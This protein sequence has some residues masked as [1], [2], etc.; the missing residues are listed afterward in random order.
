MVLA[1]VPPTAYVAARPDQVP[2]MPVTAQPAA[3]KRHRLLAWVGALVAA[4][5]IGGIAGALLSSATSDE[6]TTTELSTVEETVTEP[7][8]APAE[9]DTATEQSPATETAFTPTT[10]GTQ[11]P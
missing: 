7:G 4:L 9:P 8:F 3:P 5:V 11:G 2:V 6:N 1:T 10:S